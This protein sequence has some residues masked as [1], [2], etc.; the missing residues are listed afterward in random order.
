MKKNNALFFCLLF[1]AISC[2]AQVRI[3]TIGQ[4]FQTLP[5]HLSVADTLDITRCVA[6]YRYFYPADNFDGGFSEAEDR[7]TL[8]IGERVYKTFSYDLHLW[9]RNLTYGEKN[10]F[11]FRVNMVD[12][13]VFRNYPA[14]QLTVQRRIPYSRILQGSTQVV[15]Y[16]ESLPQT[17]WRITEKVD[18]I[19]GYRCICA[20]GRFGGRDWLVWFAP[21]LPFAVG[22]W[23]LCGLPGLILRAK[24]ATGNYRFEFDGISVKAE[25]IVLYDW[26]PV[27]MSKSKWRKTERR[28]YEHP[29]DYFS[30]NGEIEVMDSKTHRPLEGEWKVRYDPIELE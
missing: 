27:R 17:E 4:Q 6:Y 14:D 11:R 15:E 28:M 8:Q 5:A 26:H 30:K 16:N 9:D 22:P 10:K 3:T 2:Y 23:K 18:S 21:D 25:P 12:Y 1:S 20:E 19:G 29:A 13:E 24:D 7:L